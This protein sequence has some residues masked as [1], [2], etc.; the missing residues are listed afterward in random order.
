MIRVDPT[1]NPNSM[2]FTADKPLFAGSKFMSAPDQAKGIPLAERLFAVPGVA[3]VFLMQSMC[4]VNRADGADWNA[5]VPKVQAILTEA[6]P[7]GG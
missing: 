5:I 3:T 7:S 2:K 1:P 4:T 6:L